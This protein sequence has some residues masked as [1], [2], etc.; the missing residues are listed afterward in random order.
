MYE[1]LFWK[2]FVGPAVAALLWDA[3]ITDESMYNL[4]NE[5]AILRVF[6]YSVLFFRFDPLHQWDEREY[7]PT[8]W[9]TVWED[10]QHQLG[11]SV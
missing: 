10:H 11:G 5:L 7:S 3:F 2:M 8:G 6:Y 9:L 1:L 4:V